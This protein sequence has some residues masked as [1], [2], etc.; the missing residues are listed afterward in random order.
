MLSIRALDCMTE[1]KRIE[2]NFS[3]VPL[4]MA[5][6]DDEKR[7]HTHT[8]TIEDLHFLAFDDCLS[9]LFHPFGRLLASLFRSNQNRSRTRDYLQQI[10]FQD[11]R[12]LRNNQASHGTFSSLVLLLF[13]G[14]ECTSTCKHACVHAAFSFS[15]ARARTLHF[16]L[17]Q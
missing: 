8:H 3:F 10:A 6:P 9:L 2:L 13:N 11:V 15:L 12:I 5:S 1:E 7:T 4:L 17:N 14:T 16:P